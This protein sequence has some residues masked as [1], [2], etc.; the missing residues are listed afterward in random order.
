MLYEVITDVAA[1][2]ISESVNAVNSDLNLLIGTGLILIS[3]LIVYHV[4]SKIT[5]T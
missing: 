2:G 4:I 5:Y 3:L 1:S